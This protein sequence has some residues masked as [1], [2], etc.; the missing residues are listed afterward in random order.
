MSDTR[1]WHGLDQPGLENLAIHAA[2]ALVPGT[3]VY[4]RGE[5]GAGKTTF[6]RALIRA[7]T[8]GVRVKS[9]TYTLVET[10]A[11]PRFALHH[12]DLYRLAAPDELEYI[13]VRELAA[14]DAVL[15][16]EWPEKGGDALPRADLELGLAH[17]GLRRDLEAVAPS[18]SGA[19]V[20]ARLP[21]APT[22]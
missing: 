7:L 3:V 14:P 13:G 1:H 16:V 21:G 12:L 18:A 5:L 4:L 2:R 20:L 10:Y 22:R 15:L 8:P 19:A 9:P 11:M 6:A 17:A